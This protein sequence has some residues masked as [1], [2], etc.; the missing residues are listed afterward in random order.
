MSNGTG[1]WFSSTKGFG[2]IEP[3]DGGGHIFVHAS[4]L[5]RAGLLGLRDGQ[6]VSFDIETD[7]NGRTAATNLVQL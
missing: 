7:G 4:A 1:K 3:D 2:F 6:K 5:E